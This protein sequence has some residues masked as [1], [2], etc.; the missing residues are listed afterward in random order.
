[1][2]RSGVHGADTVETSGE[3]I[4]HS[5][6]EKTLTI[7]VVVDTLEESKSLRVGSLLR[8][9]VVAEILNSDVA[10]TDDVAAL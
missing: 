2:V 8:S 10:M 3:T 4:G 6:L 7:P 1:M 5:S 9:Q